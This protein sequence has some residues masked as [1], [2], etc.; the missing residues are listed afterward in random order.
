MLIRKSLVIALIMLS[1]IAAIAQDKNEDFFAAARKGDVAAVKALLDQGV[2]VNAKT[3][4]GA[5]AL[6]Y[7]CDKGHL[8]VIKLLIDRGADVN[9]KDTFYGEVPLGWALSH[10]HTQVVKLLLDKGAKG[11]DR[12]LSEGA[13][14]GNVEIVKI[15]L[16]K[17]G[18]PPETLNNVLRRASKGDNKEIIDLLKKAGAVSVEVTVE[19]A[20]LMTY[21]GKYKNDQVGEVTIEIKDG[22]LIG[23]VNTNNSFSTVAI[24]KTK[25]AINEVEATI[26]FTVEGDKVVGLELSQ[27][28]ANFKFN[29]V[30]AK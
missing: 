4:Y 25:F 20:A 2:D 5:T 26:T 15:A 13:Q 22:K 8:E 18:L 17:G 7:A 9:V 21:A 10:G 27:G 14:E 11:T 6:S 12:V 16:D 24:G 29:R 28:G 23:K 3:R 1:P 30:E 19:P